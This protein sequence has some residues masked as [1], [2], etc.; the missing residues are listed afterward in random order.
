MVCVAKV[1]EKLTGPRRKLPPDF[2]WVSVVLYAKR[3]SRFEPKVG[4]QG[5]IIPQ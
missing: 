2:F 1:L 5:E 3:V 4:T